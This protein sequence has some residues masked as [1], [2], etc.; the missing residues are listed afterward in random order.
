MKYKPSIGDKVSVKYRYWDKHNRRVS[1]IRMGRIRAIRG[2]SDDAYSICIR[3]DWS[4]FSYWHFITPNG[5][6]ILGS[7]K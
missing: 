2:Y 3:R 4:L 7:W 1:K 6:K 5:N